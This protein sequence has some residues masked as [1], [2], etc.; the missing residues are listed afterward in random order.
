M[1]SP[2]FYDPH[3]ARPKS[4]YHALSQQANF[5][6]DAAQESAVD[7]LDAWWSE[8]VAFKS[9]RNQFLGHSLL[10]PHV[11][12]G[13]YIWGGVGRGKTFL[14]DAFYACVPY[15]R[16]RRIHFHHF[17]AEVHQA[18]QQL[19]SQKDPLLTLARQIC[20][21]TRLLCLDEL[22]IDNIADAMILGR[23]FGALLEQGVILMTT[24]NYPPDGLYPDGLQ[25][26]HFLPTIALL[27]RELTVL[28]VDNGSD[29]RLRSGLRAPL[30]LTP[31]NAASE[32][33]LATMFDEITVGSV[34]AQETITILGRPIPVK[35][36]ADQ[37]VWFDFQALCGRPHGQNDYLAIAQR[38]PTVFI[39]HL[40]QM[41]AEQ[42][43]AAR[44]F[45]WLV[46]VFYD[47]RVKL[48][49]T[50]ACAPQMLY[51]DGIASSEFGR[52]ISR[53]V[54]MQTQAYMEL[55]HRGD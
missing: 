51:I 49:L 12:K 21:E 3:H 6:Y 50:A 10:N 1:S 8:L 28:N 13:M 4:W 47:C 46:D 42:A 40:P 37:A 14:M 26:Q 52:T 7:A 16:K 24:S 27:K 20:R 33:H 38:Y 19:S 17:M 44:R 25:R 15:R 22:H 53:L 41:S 55:A 31:D 2:T 34:I 36:S 9:K 18:L 54:E 45:T 32:Q 11:P 35:K 29:Y 43:A 23:L 30:Y 39:S 5:V 48:V